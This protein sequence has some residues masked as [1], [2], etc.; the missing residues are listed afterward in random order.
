MSA[1]TAGADSVPRCGVVI[2]TREGNLVLTAEKP[3]P[4]SLFGALSSSIESRALTETD[5][6]AADEDWKA[7]L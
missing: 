6:G 7:S 1:A 2:E 3:E 4:R 5:S